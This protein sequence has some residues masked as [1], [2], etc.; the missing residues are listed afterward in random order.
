[1]IKEAGKILFKA[2]GKRWATRLG[3]VS[4]HCDFLLGELTIRIEKTS[5][6]SGEGENRTIKVSGDN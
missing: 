3:P 4:M 6:F 1:L 2:A 5:P